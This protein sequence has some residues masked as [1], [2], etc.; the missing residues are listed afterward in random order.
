[1]TTI[2]PSQPVVTLINVHICK[3]ED[4]EQLVALLRQGIETIYRHV[5]GFVSAS[6]HKSLDGVR[7]TNYAQYRSREDVETAW[8]NPAI[9]AFAEKVSAL[10]ASFD[11]HLYEVADSLH[12]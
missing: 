12:V 9:P 10:V 3:P 6:V 8:Q 5:P 1:M 4:Q 11:A 7:V 2:D